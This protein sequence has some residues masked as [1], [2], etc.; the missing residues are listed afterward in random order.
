MQEDPCVAPSLQ[1]LCLVLHRCASLNVLLGEMVNDRLALLPRVL[2]TA[3][4]LGQHGSS[5]GHAGAVP[6]GARPL[7][8]G[9]DAGASSRELQYS[10]LYCSLLALGCKASWLAVQ[11]WLLKVTLLRQVQAV[12]P[13]GFQ[14]LRTFMMDAA[15]GL[16]R[17][18]RMQT[19]SVPQRAA[20]DGGSSASSSAAEP[21]ASGAAP[22]PAPASSSTLH[23]VYTSSSA[24]SAA[25]AAVA[26]AV[27]QCSP[28]PQQLALAALMHNL[29]A[30]LIDS[31]ATGSV[32]AGTV[33][34]YLARLGA[35]ELDSALPLAAG[36]HA[37][38]AHSTLLRMLGQVLSDVAGRRGM[39]AEVM[40]QGFAAYLARVMQVGH[41]HL[42][43]WLVLAVVCHAIGHVGH[44]PGHQRHACC[45]LLI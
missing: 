3:K 37:V 43:E 10:P 35:A 34:G 21:A 33:L 27:A 24:T 32:S 19:Q 42:P 25:A 36:V 12:F 40:C 15:G 11:D 38:V 9:A 6:E 26:A 28:P 7:E 8:P 45:R 16:V 5:T 30:M 44:W 4:T 13:G 20:D 23:D 31:S 14:G 2:C 18:A 41:A 29:P 39:Q 1:Q 17:Q 22:S